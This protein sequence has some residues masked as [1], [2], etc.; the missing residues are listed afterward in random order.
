MGVEGEEDQSVATQRERRW[1]AKKRGQGKNVG[2]Q[3][4]AATFV[5]DNPRDAVFSFIPFLAGLAKFQ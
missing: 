2:L 4:H 5:R 3:R 1:D